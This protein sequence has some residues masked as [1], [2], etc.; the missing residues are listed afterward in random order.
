MFFLTRKW[1]FIALYKF[2]CVFREA[3]GQR[4]LGD[5]LC[6]QIFLVEEE[7]NRC[8]CKPLVVA[9]GVKKLHALHHTVLE[10]K[11][12]VLFNSISIFK[13]MQD[14]ENLV[15]KEKKLFMLE[16]ILSWKFHKVPEHYR[17]KKDWSKVT[18]KILE[19][20]RKEGRKYNFHNFVTWE[21]FVAIAIEVWMVSIV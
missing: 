13:T 12:V 8:I 1:L 11:I 15:T 18:T 19:H 6:K 3:D 17:K 2:T 7:D 16:I 4:W 9:D 21:D 10:K 5:F 14:I 20:Q